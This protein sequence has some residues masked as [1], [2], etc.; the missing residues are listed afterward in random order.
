VSVTSSEM[1]ETAT[2]GTAD[3][4]EAT[5]DITIAAYVPGDHETSE[6]VRS[7]DGARA[8]NPNAATTASES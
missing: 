5:R 3:W 8:E 1:A 6:P 2:V 7:Q 4:V